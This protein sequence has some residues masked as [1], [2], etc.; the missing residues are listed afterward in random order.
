MLKPVMMT[1]IALEAEKE[2]SLAH[3]ELEDVR[4]LFEQ[5]QDHSE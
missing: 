2:S 1:C 4:S 5:G 3:Q